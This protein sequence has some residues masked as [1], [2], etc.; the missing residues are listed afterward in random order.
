MKGLSSVPGQQRQ[1][2]SGQLAQYAVEDENIYQLQQENDV[3]IE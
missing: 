1:V 3:I 2:E